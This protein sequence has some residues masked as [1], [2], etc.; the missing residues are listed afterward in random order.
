MQALLQKRS[1]YSASYPGMYDTSSAGH[2][3]AGEEPLPSAARE[4]KEEL[5]IDAG[6]N[7]LTF[8]GNFRIRNDTSFYGAPYLDNE[9]VFVYL[10]EKPVR[11]DRMTLQPEEVETA[12]W[13]D[14]DEVTER[15]AQGDPLFCVPVGGLAVLRTFL[16]RR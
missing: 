4:L 16:E 11:E 6:E 2:L 10:Y 8:C 9:F 15:C 3:G 12:E 7:D 5:G 1:R 13:F 14:L